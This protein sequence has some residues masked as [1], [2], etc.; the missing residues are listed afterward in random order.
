MHVNNKH[1]DAPLSPSKVRVAILGPASPFRGGIA[2]FVHN[3]ADELCKGNDIIIFSFRKQY[4]QWLFPGKSQTED[5]G[6]SYSYPIHRTLTP[7]NPI[8]FKQTAQKIVESQP[9]HLVVQFW[10]PY[11]CPAYTAIIKY[12]KKNSNIMV[13]ILCHNITFHERWLGGNWLTKKMLKLADNVIV[14]S[15]AVEGEA[16]RLNLPQITT[17]FHPIYHIGTP[18]TASEPITVGTPLAASASYSFAHIRIPQKKTVLFFGLIK[19]Y[20]GLHIFLKSIP[21]ITKRIEGIQFIIAGQVYGR[22]SKVRRAIAKLSCDNVIFRGEYIR[23][24]DVPHYFNVAD[25]VVVPY[26]S[27]TQSG[28]VQLAYSYKKP[29]I[30]SRIAGLIEMVEEG[31]TG[32]LFEKG[33]PVDLA[34]KIFLFFTQGGGYAKGI[35]KHNENNTWEFFG[36]ALL[37]TFSQVAKKKG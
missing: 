29:V 27:A 14:L 28:I 17:L 20:K 24:E 1:D 21:I 37:T 33:D 3:M 6:F 18:L 10:I 25:V 13:H 36:K 12:I 9:Q 8:T 4:P 16:K 19:K 22:A 23:G 26:L 2:Q 32:L 31:A 5:T 11:F 7:Y 35:E 30:C 34:E 15:K